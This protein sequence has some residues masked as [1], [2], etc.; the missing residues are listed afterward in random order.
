MSPADRSAVSEH[1]RQR[2]E[3]A[4]SKAASSSENFSEIVDTLNEKDV[5]DSDI[6]DAMV[7]AFN[8]IA[9]A[10]DLSIERM[11]SVIKKKGR[12]Q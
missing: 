8:S 6:C 7:D 9:Q 3:V 1:I 12:A 10:F 11:V 5:N 4:T 2:I